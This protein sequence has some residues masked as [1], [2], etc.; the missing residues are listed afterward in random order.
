MGWRE[1][2]LKVLCECNSFSCNKSITLSLEENL[3]IHTVD[4]NQ[5]IIIDGCDTEP[6]QTDEFVEKKNGY[7]LYRETQ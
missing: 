6:E 4:T 2:G 7:S 1:I 5:I 3:E